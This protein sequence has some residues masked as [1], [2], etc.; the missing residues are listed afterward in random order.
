MAAF[1]A[2][3]RDSY[4]QDSQLESLLIKW[5]VKLRTIWRSHQKEPAVDSRPD[6]A[7]GGSVPPE[8]S[9]TDQDIELFREIA[10]ASSSV[11]WILFLLYFFYNLAIALTVPWD[12]LDVPSV[13]SNST[14]STTIDFGNSTCGQ[15]SMAILV[16]FCNNTLSSTQQSL[17]PSY[18]PKFASF[19]NACLLYTVLSCGNTAL[20]MSSRTLYGL[21]TA[22]QLRNH[23]NGKVKFVAAKLGTLLTG[24]GVPMY[25]VTASVLIFCWLPFMSFKDN[26]QWIT[27]AEV[28]T[29]DLL[30][31]P[32]LQARRSDAIHY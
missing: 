29:P 17:N 22:D 12:Y 16:P 5:K 6:V 3:T 24:S 8:V 15:T 27:V 20:Y 32:D 2:K 26:E 13:F 10:W 31:D 9:T 23:A 18:N 1:E 28:K 4:S 21:V 19:I 25:A 30:T 7:R 11:H 14:T